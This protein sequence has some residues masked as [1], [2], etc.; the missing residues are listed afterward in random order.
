VTEERRQW[1]AVVEKLPDR[2][3]RVWGVET[4]P[5]EAILCRPRN[6]SDVVCMRVGEARAQ[7]LRAVIVKGGAPRADDLAGILDL[8]ERC[9]KAP[10]ISTVWGAWSKAIVVR[11]EHGEEGRA[12]FDASVI[13]PLRSLFDVQTVDERD[14]GDRVMW[15]TYYGEATHRDSHGREVPCYVVDPGEQRG[16]GETAARLARALG[17]R[18]TAAHR[19]DALVC[20]GPG[21][22]WGIE[23]VP[24]SP[25]LDP[26]AVARGA[27]ALLELA[28]F[29]EEEAQEP[30][31]VDAAAVAAALRGKSPGELAGLL[32]DVPIA[33][34]AA[35]FG[36]RLRDEAFER[37]DEALKA[38]C[39]AFGVR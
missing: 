12:I 10:P 22:Y 28:G 24:E 29:G 6:G 2:C 27:R 38:L 14:S 1:W 3:A 39:D 19:P 15:G 13:E 18:P 21:S 32:A 20:D 7:Q 35:A 31:E 9:A 5:E 17:Y 4:T 16:P 33:H 23:R 25:E 26:E 30:R 11:E 34:L 8:A 37:V 36:A